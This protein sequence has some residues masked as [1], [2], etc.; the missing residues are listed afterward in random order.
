MRVIGT[1]VNKNKKAKL[2]KF[3]VKIENWGLEWGGV[4]KYT[5]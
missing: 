2:T 3:V 4:I 5:V 1:L